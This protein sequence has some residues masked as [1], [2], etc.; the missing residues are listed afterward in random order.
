MATISTAAARGSSSRMPIQFD[1][2]VGMAWALNPR[3]V[4]RVAGG[5]F[6]DG[7]G[8]AFGQQGDGNVA[9]RL[10]RT[11][12]YTDFDSYLNAGSAASPVPNTNGPVRTDNRRPNNLPLHRRRFSAKSA[13]T[14]SSMPRMSA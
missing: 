11:I 12:F 9:Y 10:N 1:P 2:R 4:I 6:H 7:T 3:T 14:S 13:R 8:G 5:S